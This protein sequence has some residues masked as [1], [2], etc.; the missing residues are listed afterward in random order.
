[1]VNIKLIRALESRINEIPQLDG[2]FIITE[3]GNIYTDFPNNERIFIS[4]VDGKTYIPQVDDNYNLTWSESGTPPINAINIKGPKGDKGVPGENGIGIETANISPDGVLFIILT[5]GTS[6]SVGNVRGPQGEKG[7]LGP[8][9]VKGEKG[10]PFTI[11]K[12]YASV[13]DMNLGF[14]TDGVPEGGF[15]IIETGNVYDVDN[16]KLYIKGSDQYEFVTD[17]SGAQGMQGPQGIQGIQ[18]PKGDPGPAGADGTSVTI[19]NITESTTDAG[20]NI[21]TFSNGQTITIKNGSKGSQ[22]IQGEQGP[23]GTAVTIQDVSQSPVDG[24]DNVV[25]FSDGTTLTIKNG[26]QGSTGDAGIDGTSATHTWD[27]SNLIITSASG[28]STINIDEMLQQKLDE[29]PTAASQGAIF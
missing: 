2:Q 27:G 16:A 10:D 18:G 15:V 28:T 23:A 8:Q 24:G 26:T 22:G 21:I 17:L 6:L 25:T 4:G 14:N 5:D 1:M 19:T 13:S 29:I 11:S 9:G 7:E 3:Q 20:N 12:V